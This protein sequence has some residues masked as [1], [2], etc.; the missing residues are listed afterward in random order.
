MPRRWRLWVQPVMVLIYSALIFVVL[1]LVIVHLVKSGANTV[2]IVWFIAGIF[3]MMA[4][5]MALWEITQHLLHYTQPRLQKFIIRILWMVPIYALN[6]WLGLTFPKYAFYMNTLR[7]CYEAFVIYSFLMFLLHFLLGEYPESEIVLVSLSSKSPIKHMCPLCCFPKWK[8]GRTL[9]DRCRHGILQYTVVRP[10]TTAIAFLCEILD[11]YGEGKFEPRYA[12]PYLTAVNNFSQFI[13]MYCLV[14]FYRAHKAELQPIDPLGKFLCIKSVVFFSFFQG[15]IISILVWTGVISS[16]FT[17]EDQKE[18]ILISSSLQN[19]L[20]CLE[21]FLAA[22]AHLF[23]FSH[24]PYIDPDMEG[25]TCWGSF[26]AMWDI[27]DIRNDVSDHFRVV[28]STMRRSVWDRREPQVA[29]VNERT[30]L[31]YPDEDSL[32]ATS[33]SAGVKQAK[34]S[35]AV[36]KMERSL[37]SF[38]D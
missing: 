7:E 26:L 36:G 17:T 12:F 18:I 15:V 2:A 29:E 38:V 37:I 1:P 28:G 22:L 31:V 23:A 35:S 30:S 33:S 14:L 13:A 16:A 5:P 19:F 34:S 8:M 32:M 11:V 3:V 25:V 10:V 21:M 6:A 4:V 9:I 27:S 24:R 20:L